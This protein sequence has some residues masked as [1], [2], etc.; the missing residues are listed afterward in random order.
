MSTITNPQNPPTGTQVAV[1]AGTLQGVSVPMPDGS[2][3]GNAGIDVLFF[4]A[5]WGTTVNTLAQVLALT[6]IAEVKTPYGYAPV[7]HV[8][9]ALDVAYTHGLYAYQRSGSSI[10][11]TVS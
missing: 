11:V 1:G 9:V 10:A 8:A 2:T 6:P 3:S 7:N 4:D 5:L